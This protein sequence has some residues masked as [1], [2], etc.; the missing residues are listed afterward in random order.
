[1]K[2]LV[3][4]IVILFVVMSVVT[5]RS[6]ESK[7][8]ATVKDAAGVVSDVTDIRFSAGDHLKKFNNLY[9]HIGLSAD[10]FDIAIPI[11]NLISVEAKGDSHAVSYLWR[12][13]ELTITGKLLSEEFAGKSDFGDLKLHTSKLLSLNFHQSPKPEEKKE[14]VSERATL[15]LE[16]GTQIT[17]NTFRRHDRYYSRE[18]YIIGGRIRY[19]HYTD[20]RFLRGESL[21]TVKFAEIKRIE[22]VGEKEVSVTLKNGKKASGTISKEKGADING[23]TGVFEK[24]EFFVEKKRVK[25]I[26]F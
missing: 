17:V 6:E 25:S 13:K 23:F 2:R 24:G 16:D 12:G 15:T 22:F 11:D 8:T 10:L 21:I 4:S 19:R 7:R 14:E 26:D 5:A 9:R 3:C 20:F 18:G 1:M